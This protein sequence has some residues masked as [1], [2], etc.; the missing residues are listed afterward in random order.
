MA[1]S[2]R[3]QALLLQPKQRS[4]GSVA[5]IGFALHTIHEDALSY[6]GR[7]MSPLELELAAYK[8]GGRDGLTIGGRSQP[9]SVEVELD[10]NDGDLYTL[11]GYCFNGTAAVLY[12]LERGAA[13]ADADASTQLVFSGEPEFKGTTVKL[14]LKTKQQDLEQPFIDFFQAE[15][16]HLHFPDTTGNRIELPA[17]C[18]IRIYPTWAIE[19]WCKPQPFSGVAAANGIVGF[20][21][22]GAGQNLQ[23]M[24][25]SLASAAWEQSLAFNMPGLVSASRPEPLVDGRWHW[26]A[27][28]WNGA[29]YSLLIDDWE[30]YEGVGAYFDPSAQTQGPVTVG[31]ITTGGARRYFGGVRQIRF[32]KAAPSN[33]Y[34]TSIRF[35]SEVED[36]RLLAQYMLN[37][38]AS[39]DVVGTRSDSH[40]FDTAITKAGDGIGEI[41]G[42]PEWLPVAGQLES[43]SSRQPRLIGEFR[44][45]EP[46]A[47]DLRSHNYRLSDEPIGGVEQLWTGGRLLS[48]DQLLFAGPTDYVTITPGGGLTWLDGEVRYFRIVFVPDDGAVDHQ[49]I[50]HNSGGVLWDV[51]LE[52]QAGLGVGS[53]VSNR[54][55]GQ[56]LKVVVEFDNGGGNP[57]NLTSQRGY[58]SG[59]PLTIDIRARSGRVLGLKVNGSHEGTAAMDSGTWTPGG[60]ILLFSDAYGVGRGFEHGES[61]LLSDEDQQ[62]S[63]DQGVRAG[64]VPGVVDVAVQYLFDEGTGTTLN[65]QGS[66][67]LNGAITGATW[68]NTAFTSRNGPDGASLQSDAGAGGPLRVQGRGWLPLGHALQCNS[69]ATTDRAE[70]PDDALLRVTGDFTAFVRYRHVTPASFNY[71]LYK[72]NTGVEGSFALQARSTDELRALLIDDALATVNASSGAGFLEEGRWYW[73][74]AV[75]RSGTGMELWVDG[76]KEAEDLTSGTNTTNNTTSD[77]LIGAGLDGGRAHHA[78]IVDRA[79]EES[80]ILSQMGDP[81]RWARENVSDVVAYWPCHENTGST[82]ADLGPDA[83]RGDLV[84]MDWADG[85]YPNTATECMRWLLLRSGEV[86]WNQFDEES[87]AEFERLAKSST[88][89]ALVGGRYRD[90]TI[91]EVIDDLMRPHGLWGFDEED[92]KVFATYVIPPDVSEVAKLSGADYLQIPAGKVWTN[93]LGPATI[94]A[95]IRNFFWNATDDVYWYQDSGNHVFGLDSSGNI[96]CEWVDSNNDQTKVYA[97]APES[98]LK[99]TKVHHVAVSKQAVILDGEELATTITTSFAFYGTSATKYVGL[100]SGSDRMV[101]WVREL[102]TFTAN[103]EASEVEK[104]RR[105]SRSGT[106]SDLAFY[107]PMDEA[108]GET[109]TERITDQNASWPVAEPERE[110]ARVGVY[111]PHDLT[112]TRRDTRDPEGMKLDPPHKLNAVL[113]SRNWDPYRVSELLESVIETPGF[114]TYLVDPWLEEKIQAQPDTGCDEFTMERAPLQTAYAL[115]RVARRAG[116]IAA[117]RYGVDRQPWSV[118]AL[119]NHR[120]RMGTMVLLVQDRGGEEDDTPHNGFHRGGEVF[121]LLS[122]RRNSYDEITEMVLWG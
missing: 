77:V 1:T 74:H 76:V 93:D 73:I 43:N 11:R 25:G 118:L 104:I 2:K 49:L 84:G 78:G 72:W 115:R 40:V 21:D 66:S 89:D 68:A 63:A 8:S 119:G 103:L 60:S 106:E 17:E 82:I 57:I 59:S 121:V 95:W 101:G 69:A 58:L 97:P 6:R 27:M 79:M 65:D 38:G 22:G 34:L 71:P 5:S 81:I 28:V 86:V 23:L 56:V 83:H 88:D 113:F 37:E 110:M 4:D 99:G 90:E 20:V 70:V 75:W 32:W 31:A 42:S 94:M 13:I 102:Q 35:S 120:L 105:L 116:N 67:G 7:I 109:V 96:F 24:A 47:E 54:G 10:N 3:N 44:G 39:I 85:V 87:L 80:E 14:S 51:R 108:F 98:L 55:D 62:P 33:E 18:D 29:R 36:E 30:P 45:V 9:G 41:F 114:R 26:C 92:G 52:S 46:D 117:A 112:L 91:A 122:S 100:T 61:T 15:P 50:Y 19:F 111:R 53:E 48:A 12:D 64:G 16:I 107:L